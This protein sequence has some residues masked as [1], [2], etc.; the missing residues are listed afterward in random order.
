[1]SEIPHDAAAEQLEWL[2]RRRRL[3]SRVVGG[4]VLVVAVV[5]FVVE[6]SQSVRVRFWFWSGHPPLIWVILAC[7]AVGVVMG[8]LVSRRGGRPRWRRHDQREPK[9]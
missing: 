8:M 9:A 5:S 2:K 7:L 4:L 3:T 1:M 6:N